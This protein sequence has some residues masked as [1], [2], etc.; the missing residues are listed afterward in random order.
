MKAN[1]SNSQPAN[2]KSSDSPRKVTGRKRL[3]TLCH[4]VRRPFKPISVTFTKNC[5]SVL[6]PKQLPGFTIVSRFVHGSC[7]ADLSARRILTPQPT[8]AES[9]AHP[10]PRQCKLCT[11]NTFRAD[12]SE[13]NVRLKVFYPLRENRLALKCSLLVCN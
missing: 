10:Q 8:A 2:R 13:P 9:V 11:C 12:I 1:T 4:S 5:T 7:R 6:E 3:L